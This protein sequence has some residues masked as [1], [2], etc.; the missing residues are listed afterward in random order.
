VSS[1]GIGGTNA[2]VVLEESPAAPP[3]AAATRE[4]LLVL[5]AKSISAL[6]MASERLARHL[7]AY[8]GVNLEDVAYTLQAGR[9]AFEFAHE[10]ARCERS[11]HSIHVQW[12]R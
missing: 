2:H 10:P 6:D 9:R 7:E 11:D 1:F 4:Q 3:A 12:P 8:P 5:S